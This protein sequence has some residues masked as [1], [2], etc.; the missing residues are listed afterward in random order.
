MTKVYKLVIDEDIDE[1]WKYNCKNGIIGAEIYYLNLGSK[2][3]IL[4][5]ISNQDKAD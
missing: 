4:Y 2:V 5:S 1:N 3:L